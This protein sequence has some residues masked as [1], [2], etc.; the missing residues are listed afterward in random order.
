MNLELQAKI[1]SWRQKAAVGEMTEDEMRE[2][3]RFLREGRVAALNA[4]KP[5]RAKA[6]QAPAAD[7]MLSELGDL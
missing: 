6:A 1:S 5:G 2:A 3:I 4:S 7:D